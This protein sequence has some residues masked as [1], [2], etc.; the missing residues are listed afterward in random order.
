MASDLLRPLTAREELDVSDGRR[1]ELELPIVSAAGRRV[2]RRR[3][4]GEGKP[5]PDWGEDRFDR[6]R[7]LGP[8]LHPTRRFDDRD[9]FTDESGGEV[10]RG[11]RPAPRVADGF[12]P[13]D[14]APE[15]TSARVR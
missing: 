7:S 11:P 6:P 12:L 8:D 14:F 9:P 10:G 1:A 5:G 4:G 13:E 3:E 15:R 2:W